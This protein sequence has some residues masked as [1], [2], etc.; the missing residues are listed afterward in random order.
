MKKKKNA[1]TA[2]LVDQKTT[3]C[4]KCNSSWDGGS[5]LET[6]IKQ[7][8]AGADC[9]K[10]KSDKQLESYMKKSYSTPYRWERLMRIEIQGG[11]DGISYGRC[12]DCQTTWN[13]FSGEEEE[14][15][16]HK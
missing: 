10:G 4:P 12:P 15:P 9:W 11:Y 3:I 8:D 1:E 2:R 16:K 13:R 5:M 6:F 14:L 7:R